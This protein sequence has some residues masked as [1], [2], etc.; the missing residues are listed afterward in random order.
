[1]L[2]IVIPCYNAAT[3][4]RRA[5][6]SVMRQH[7]LDYEIIIVN[8]GSTDDSSSIIAQL[9]SEDSRIKRVDKP[10]G[11]VSSARNAGY[12]VA[13]GEYIFFL[14]A[15][16]EIDDNFA[17]STIPLMDKHPDMVLFA[18]DV[19]NANGT[20]RTF[21]CTAHKDPIS[22]YLLGMLR[23]SICSL[24]FRKEIADRNAIQFD[25]NT[26]YSE[27]R[28][29]VVRLLQCQQSIVFCNQVLFHYR[30]CASSAMHKPM[31]GEKYLTSLQAMERVFA[32]VGNDTAQ[33][34]AALTQ[35]NLTI[36]LHIRQYLRSHDRDE[37][38]WPR[39]E[40]YGKYLLS[41]V[42]WHANTYSMYVKIM[43][44]IY[45]INKNLLYKTLKHF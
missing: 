41:P 15:D 35:L 7:D 17:K 44:G 3:T 18:F 32:I 37:T 19:E 4:I 26:Y 8:D 38:L 2:S 9:V 23:I 21:T 20:W 39:L 30:Y 10:N 5:V 24:I 14:D 22:A 33:A 34:D 25:E 40:A 31:Y 16:D 1:M 36:L 11:G 43:S 29:Y 42:K 13:R 45:R 6:E 27:D 12:N 28:E